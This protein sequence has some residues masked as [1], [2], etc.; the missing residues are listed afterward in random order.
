MVGEGGRWNE[1]AQRDLVHKTSAGSR[2]DRPLFIEFIRR[3]L[4]ITEVSRH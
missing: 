3:S 4:Y 2:T 1:A